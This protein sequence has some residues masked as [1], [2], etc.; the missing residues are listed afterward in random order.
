LSC[1]PFFSWGA[2]VSDATGPLTDRYH[3][4]VAKLIVD[5]SSSVTLVHGL[6]HGVS[7]DYNG[8][9]CV[10]TR[11]SLV[12]SV[13]SAGSDVNKPRRPAIV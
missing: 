7:F 1:F 3:L 2:A 4:I 9:Y 12:D 13:V 10:D 8:I 11:D 5:S 6:V